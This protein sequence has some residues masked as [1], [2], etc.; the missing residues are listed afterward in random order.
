[1]ALLGDAAHLSLP[2]R[3]SGGAMANK[4][5]VSLGVMLSKGVQPHELPERLKL[6]EKARYERATTIQQMTRDSSAECK[7]LFH[8]SIR[9]RYVV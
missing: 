1:M 4:D 3:G 2:Y 6:Y 7:P 9:W 8:H 5:G